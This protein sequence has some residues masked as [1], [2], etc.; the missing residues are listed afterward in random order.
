MNNDS[1]GSTCSCGATATPST[2]A[3]GTPSCVTCHRSELKRVRNAAKRTCHKCGATENLSTTG[4]AVCTD[5]RQSGV[6]KEREC[7]DCSEPFS[8]RNNSTVCSTCKH[9]RQKAR[10]NR[11]CPK[12][13]VMIDYRARYCGT[14]LPR[15]PSNA[16][17]VGHK[18][19]ESNGYVE[20]KTPNGWMREHVHIMEQHLGR[21]VIIGETVHHKNGVRNDNR[22]EN[23][24]LWAK[25][26]PTGARARDLLA[27]AHEIIDRYEGL[28][29]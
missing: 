28:D 10:V 24:E 2:V 9:L 3:N 6:L 15:N 17:P 4:R 27:W 18:R 21:Q 20:V 11:R 25:A 13:G 12:C 8:T 23:L 29:I 7:K 5:C 22:I 19:T 16:V 14:C 26:Q 1:V